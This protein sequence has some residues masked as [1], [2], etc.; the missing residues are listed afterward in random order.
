MRPTLSLVSAAGS[1]LILPLSVGVAQVPAQDPKP[2]DAALLSLIVR[3][4]A[5]EVECTGYVFGHASLPDTKLLAEQLRNDHAAFG[6]EGK[7]LAE[8]LGLTLNPG[9]KSVIA[10]SHAAVLGDLHNMSGHNLD[11]AFV[12]HE[13]GLLAFALNHLN[14]VMVP[15]AKDPD[16]KALLLRAGPLLQA[17]LVLAKE[18]LE[19]VRKATPG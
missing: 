9:I 5:V 15:A 1:A 13:I 16:V 10:D 14:R 7:K 4:T 3:V 11:R 2:D 12:D 19:K 8:R 17:H 18:A 6:A